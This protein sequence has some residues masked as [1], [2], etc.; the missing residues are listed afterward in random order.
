MLDRLNQP[1]GSTIG[2]LKDGR[3][4]QEALDATSR[5]VTLVNAVGDGIADDTM[6][7]R[8]ALAE[9]VRTGYPL[10]VT[11]GKKY[12]LSDAV[13][14][15]SNIV[16]DGT[17]LFIQTAPSKAGLRIVADG[18]SVTGV[19][20]TPSSEPSSIHHAGIVIY[21]ANHCVVTR[22][23]ILYRGRTDREGH[24]IGIFHG[25]DNLIALCTASGANLTEGLEHPSGGNDFFVYGNS[26]RN[27][28]LYNTGIGKNVRGILQQTSISGQQCNYNTYDG[29]TSIGHIGYG[30][31]CYELV[32][33]ASTKMYGT[34]FRNGF[35]ANISGS[36]RDPGTGK[37]FFGAGVYN[38]EGQETR[39]EGYLI[40]NVCQDADIEETL[41]MGGV[42][43]TRGD[44]TVRN[45]T[46]VGSGRCGVK[47]TSTGLADDARTPTVKGLR[48]RNAAREALY[49]V[50]TNR[51]QVEDLN[52]TASGR[53]IR[54]TANSAYG[55]SHINI[56]DVVAMGSE[57]ILLSGFKIATV[58]GVQGVGCAG[59]LSVD[60]TGTLLA[61]SLSSDSGTGTAFSIASTVASGFLR[62][63]VAIDGATGFNLAAQITYERLRAEGNS[64]NFTGRYSSIVDGGSDAELQVKNIQYLSVGTGAD[65]TS[66]VGGVVNQVVTIR[67][68]AARTFVHNTTSLV[69]KGGANLAATP[70][71]VVQLWC[72]GNSRWIQI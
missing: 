54:A 29:N 67:V 49:L 8:E 19:K 70:N 65:I 24:G 37:K 72:I 31:I 22:C 57:G 11:G 46:I 32:H 48:V 28:V 26:S 12:L 51:A 52:V 43:S 66:L 44:V 36:A 71:T 60:N 34:V 5:V 58:N 45:I 1:R 35:V 30:H 16:G 20:V 23:N 55:S 63:S 33:D 3:S 41:P 13:D 59:L 62:D 21:E 14:V 56:S 38:Q 17:C 27:T 18:V 68:T 9:S 25:N 69:L 50:N 7:V 39:I 15:A 6:K 10:S 64:T 42:S 2:I 47:I 4:V 61:S 40:Q 53:I